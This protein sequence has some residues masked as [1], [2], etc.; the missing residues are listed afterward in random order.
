MSHIERSKFIVAKKYFDH[1]FYLA[2]YNDIAAAG[3]DPFEHFM[4]HGWVEGRDPNHWFST[5]HYRDAY[6][7]ILDPDTNPF[8]HYIL[9][10]KQ[11]GFHTRKQLE[12]HG[13]AALARPH[14]NESYYLFCNPDVRNSEI[15]PLQHYL[16]YGWIEG[17]NPSPDFH[18][19][20]YLQA[21]P[22]V[23]ESGLNPLVHF[24]QIGISEGRSG[25]TSRTH[26]P[27]GSGIENYSEYQIYARCQDISFPS[28]L[29]TTKRVI[30]VIVPEH[31]AMSGGIYSMFSIARHLNMQKANHGFD[32]VVMTNP[33]PVGAT[34]VRQRHFRNNIDV[35][36]FEQITYCQSAEEVYIHLPEYASK[37]FISRCSAETLKYLASRKT[38]YIN[39]LNQNI[40]LMPEKSN[41]A[42][43]RRFCDELTQSVA[44]HA[45]YTQQ[46]ADRYDLP[47]LLLPAYTDLSEYKP[48]SMKEKEDLIIYS[49]DKSEFKQ[50]CLE[51]I[52][53][54]F[55]KYKLVEIFNV[56]FEHYMDLATRC[57]FSISFGEGYDGYIAQPIHQGG[58][59][60]TVYDS[61]FFPSSEYLK[62]P[63]IFSSGEEMIKNICDVIEQL[64]GNPD[65]Y[66]KLNQELN[67]EHDKLYRYDD[68]VLNIKKLAFRQ[69][70]MKPRT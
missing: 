65:Q 48:T 38:L 63:N 46:I 14:F 26:I 69:F 50:G 18:T 60:F 3:V 52:S 32:V 37:G 54:R 33:N 4:E 67:H 2:T 13:E 17:R 27:I 53:R 31:N 55:P 16:Q 42:D 21:Y 15:E 70:E 29:E 64:E 8:L 7:D 57:R 12:E 56:S 35:Y 45:Y 51:E 25:K 34:Y 43:L 47:T 59:G 44:H 58:I 28:H 5:S 23:A 41:F 11:L 49:Y 30:V 39:L 22:D 40:Q 1:E 61:D 19:H 68:Y 36:R 20:Y 9:E 10:G 6:S 24:A 66:S 62:F